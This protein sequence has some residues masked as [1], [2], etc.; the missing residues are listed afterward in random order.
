MH[1]GK[2]LPPVPRPAPPPAPV[3]KVEAKEEEVKA[4]TPWQKTMREVMAVTGSF[5]E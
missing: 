5:Y 2:I 4:I 1:N 3:Q